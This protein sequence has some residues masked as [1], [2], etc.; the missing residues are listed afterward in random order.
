M[1]FDS[2]IPGLDYVPDEPPDTT[3]DYPQEDA[4]MDKYYKLKNNQ[5]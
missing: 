4:D 1:I 5:E 3:D 2:S